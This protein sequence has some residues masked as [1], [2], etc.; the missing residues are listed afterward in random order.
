MPLHATGCTEV[1]KSFLYSGLSHQ[2]ELRVVYLYKSS[3]TTFAK[4]ED[5]TNLLCLFKL[6]PRVSRQSRASLTSNGCT[7]PAVRLRANPQELIAQPI[8]FV[9]ALT[10]N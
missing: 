1:S 8:D 7:L 2:T 10:A 9:E 5:E 6:E 4:T 3:K